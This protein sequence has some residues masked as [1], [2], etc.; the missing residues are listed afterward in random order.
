MIEISKLIARSKNSFEDDPKK[1]GS[2]Q[3]DQPLVVT[4]NTQRLILEPIWQQPVDDIEGPLYRQY[5]RDNPKYDSIFLRREVAKRLYLAAE[6]LPN[7]LKLVIRAGHRPL[8]VQRKVLQGVLER[9]LHENPFATHEKALMYAR[10]FVDD[11][12]IKFP[13]HCC[14][15]AVDVDIFDINSQK[16]V[17]FG[18]QVNTSTDISFLHSSKINE[19]QYANRMTLLTAMLSASFAPSFVEWWHFSYGDTVWAYFYEKPNSLYGVVE[20]TL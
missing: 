19:T 2:L 14:G 16:L 7:H 18:S 15:S 9:Y 17:D 13:S 5:I 10:T 3:K 6:N 1:L 11:P 4:H 8:P 12:A 20:P